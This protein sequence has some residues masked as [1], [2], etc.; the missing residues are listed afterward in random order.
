[1][2]HLHTA[3]IFDVT[4]T[5]ATAKYKGY[6]YVEDVILDKGKTHTEEFLKIIEENKFKLG[7]PKVNKHAYYG[8]YIP[9]K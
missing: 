9:I 8:L 1:M 4:L 6:E 3:N 7:I 2:N 5:P